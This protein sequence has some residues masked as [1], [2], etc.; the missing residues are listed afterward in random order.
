[1]FITKKLKN[2]LIFSTVFILFSAPSIHLQSQADQQLTRP[3]LIV[4]IVV[5]QMRYDYLY[6]YYD[7]YSNG[8]FKRML[9]EGFN[10]RSHHY[11]YPN[12]S[13]GA[14]HA[15]IYTGSAPAI[16]GIVGNNWFDSR[17]EESI[18]CVSDNLVQG[19]G[20][21]TPSIGKASPRNML[22]STVSDQLR[23]AT[24]FESKTISIALK[25]RG[26]ILPGGHTANAAYWYDGYTGNWI[27]STFYMETLP[28]WVN[29]FNARKLP[30]KYLREG[31]KTLLPVEQYTESTPD[32]QPWEEPMPGN[33]RPVFPYALAGRSGDAFGMAGITPI[34]NVL[35]K[36]MA[37]ASIKG[38]DLGKRN[39]TDFLALSF[40]A[41]DGVGHRYGPNSVEQQDLY[42]RLDLELADLFSFL[43]NWVGKGQYTVFLSADH[44]VVDVPEFSQKH[45]LPSGR[46][47][48]DSLHNTIRNAIASEFDDHELVK[49]I[50]IGMIYLDKKRMRSKEI[51]I[52]EVVEVVQQE[53]L[54]W[55]GVANVFN[56]HKLATTTLTDYQRSLFANGFHPKRSG[57][58]QVLSQPGWTSREGFGTSH[59]S[60]YQYDTHVPFVM[61]G[62]GIRPGETF[63]RTH[64]CDIAPTL[65]ALLQIL[66]PSGNIGEVVE[67]AFIR[68]P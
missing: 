62:W 22:V 19:V 37:I 18:N 40:S 43:D 52:D 10:C 53:L 17:Y 67:E 23:I 45:R 15:S 7:K 49:S 39:V 35:T 5:D 14:G 30:T 24:N 2:S 51:T 33:D 38:E 16:H 6:R 66:P 28:Q 44:G 48:R 31:W 3:K 13:T 65:S 56:C 46:S 41:P 29:D 12:T 57:D 1:M 34:G 32:D 8:G 58:I 27:T 59:G 25:D 55:E 9:R 54:P 61:F 47:S 68:K 60:P 26:S 11:H 20:G 21:R 50:E 64:I 4:G 42:L 63:R 36:D